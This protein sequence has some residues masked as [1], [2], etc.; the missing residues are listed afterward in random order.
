MKLRDYQEEAVSNTLESWNLA[1]S[2]LGCCPTGGGKT[3]IAGEVI[4][5]RGGRAMV[6]C[7]T[8]ELVSQFA[9]SLWRFGLDSE[10]EKAD[11]WADTNS[12]HGSPVVIA[13]PQ[14]LFS[15]GGKRLQRWKPDD[16]STLI[17]DEGHHYSGAPAFEKVVKHF[18]VN[19]ELRCLAL[20][21]TPDRHDGIALARICDSV[22]FKYEIVDMI[23]KGY[24][25]GVEQYLVK[26]ESLDLSKCRT[27]AGDLSNADLAEVV[28]QEKP[29]LGMADATLKTV[30]NKKTLVFAHSVK[31]AERMAEIFNRHKPGSADCVFGHTPDDKRLD[32]FRRFSDERLQ[33]MVNVAVAG[34]GY[35]NPNIEAIVCAKPTKSRA[36][37]T[38]QIGR[39]LRPLDDL[40][41][42]LDSPEERRMAI[43]NSRKPTCMVLDFVGNAGRH[44]L[45]TVADVLGGRISE[46]AKQRAKAKILKTGRGNMLDELTIAEREL[47]E[48]RERRRRMGI[49]ADSKHRLTYVDPFESFR[50]KAKFWKS[51]K[52]QG[53]LSTKQRLT[54]RRHGYDPEQFTPEQGQQVITK[55]F[56]LSPA[57]ENVL[58]RAGYS[59]EEL[60][61]I[62][63]W[64][65]SQMIDRVKA[66]NWRRPKA[67]E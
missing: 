53:P 50:S 23:D 3:V 29:L 61:G 35:D 34:E 19:P 9:K 63:K 60:T 62:P 49:V 4:K 43:A 28:E 64:V 7:H 32:I 14:T 48:E 33:I 59:R 47:L 30:G 25:V 15:R 13:T 31:Q 22:A 27:V 39:G 67:T 51:Y 52:Q 24:L 5:R 17:V 16:F 21:A 6:L 38:Q 44:S 8:G 36:R 45:M 57:Q 56:S 55:I 46:Q 1:A 42:G 65:A 20:T 37:Y 40:L 18:L 2:V 12:L 58:V 54:L 41:N 66:N 26:I 11:L 10:I